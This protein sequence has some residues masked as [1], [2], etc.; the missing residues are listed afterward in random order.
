MR[1]SMRSRLE[2]M[3]GGV[4][5]WVGSDAY[6]AGRFG[7]TAAFMP[8]LGIFVLATFFFPLRASDE[9]NYVE[10]AHNLLAGHFA[11]LGW[12]PAT[13]YGTSADPANPDLWFGPGLPGAL[14]PLVALDLPIEVLRLTGALFLF[15]AVLVFHRLLRLH[16]GKGTSLLGAY[17]L[18]AYFPFY[19]LLPTIHSE[20]LAILLIVAML[21][22]LS[23]YL[24]G[25]RHAYGVAAAAAA[26]GVALTRVA[27]G[28]VLT[29]MVVAFG[30]WWLVSRRRMVLRV[31]GVFALAL[32][33]CLPWLAF[34]HSVTD[35]F[36][37]WGNSG[38]LSLYWMSSPYPQDL[39]D[40]RG[41]AYEVVVTD[42][43]LAHHRDFF[44]ELA[45][46]DPT[47]QNRRLEQRAIENIRGS[48][49][50]FAENVAANVSRMF[51]GFPFSA[52]PETLNTLFY[53]VPN[54]IILW[55]VLG[56]A[57]LVARQPGSFPPEGIVFAAFAVFGLALHAVLAAF[58][59]ML[60]PLIP[61]ALWF[62]FHTIGTVVLPYFARTRGTYDASGGATARSAPS[63]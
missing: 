60:M 10:L 15:G 52:K 2:R 27:Y 35:R 43:K 7:T 22:L 30:L 58:P 46:L 33:F 41:G 1:L 5:R 11:G 26:A 14:S 21:Y 25:G 17:A 24:A 34:T 62:V 38:S 51:F 4:R 36:F 20:P 49:G 13:P 57:L 28:W 6:A 19:L 8:L 31:V 42:A 40:W 59:R 39:G 54:S 12:R 44:L 23:R 37:V 32:A 18:G 53:L 29:G 9:R 50:K 48:P 3:R 55:G 47:E 56:C 61:I 16:V 63:M 45:P